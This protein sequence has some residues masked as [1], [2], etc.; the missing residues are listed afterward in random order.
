M[1]NRQY[2]IQSERT[3][4]FKYELKTTPAHLIMDNVLQKHICEALFAKSPRMLCNYLKEK[5]TKQS[6][7]R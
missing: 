3:P 7:S 2:N 6:I 1:C 4:Y 5:N